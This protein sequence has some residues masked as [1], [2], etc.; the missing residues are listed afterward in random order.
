MNTGY[1]TMSLGITLLQPISRLVTEKNI[2]GYINPVVETR[3]LQMGKSL[4][5]NHTSVLSNILKNKSQ[6]RILKSKIKWSVI[7]CS[8]KGIFCCLPSNPL[9]KSRSFWYFLKKK[10]KALLYMYLTHDRDQVLVVEVSWPHDNDQV[11][12]SRGL[13]TSAI[14]F[15]PINVC[16]YLAIT[17]THIHTLNANGSGS[18][19]T[20]CFYLKYQHTPTA[21]C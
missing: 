19:K 1:W 17:I 5:F 12:V 8:L 21:V 15:Q 7:G 4:E 16:M 10:W 11:S 18:R 3:E 2:S 14:H 20:N 9:S 13:V 6:G